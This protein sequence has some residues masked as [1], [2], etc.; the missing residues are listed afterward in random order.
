MEDLIAMVMM[1]SKNYYLCQVIFTTLII[2]LD[3]VD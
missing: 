3:L 1:K 2:H